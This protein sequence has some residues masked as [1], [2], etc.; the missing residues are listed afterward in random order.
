M[1][2]IYGYARCSTNESRQD[3]TRQERELIAMGADKHNI[4][5]EYA[6]GSKEDRTEF[7]K[8]LKLLDEG[9]TIVCTEVSRLSRSTKQLC[10]VIQLVKDK[11]LK[12]VIGAFVVD[13]TKGE[14]DVMTEGMLKMMAVFA[15]MEI[16]MTSARIKSG[17]ENAVSKGK[18]LGRPEVTVDDLPKNFFRYYPQYASG[19]M[20]KAAFARTCECSRQSI[21]KYIELYESSL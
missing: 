9:D 21:Y 8:L 6:K 1:G 19:Q 14:I 15:E 12:L 2:T 11:H 18:K 4:Y 20:S 7:Q 3:I 16:Q 10:E 17:L 5:W 13:C